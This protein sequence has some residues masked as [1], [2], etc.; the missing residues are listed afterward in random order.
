MLLSD[1]RCWG[2]LREAVMLSQLLLFILLF[3]PLH[4]LSFQFLRDTIGLIF[5]DTLYFD[6]FSP[7]F[8]IFFPLFCF[9]VKLL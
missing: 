1:R 4:N 2:A 8:S 6:F 9:L 5:I 3:L 7:S